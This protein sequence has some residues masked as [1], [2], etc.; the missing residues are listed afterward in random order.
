M[1]KIVKATVG[2]MVVTII[3]KLLGFMREIVLGS[4][5]GATF[6]SD[7]YITAMN[8]PS[9]IFLSVGTAIGTIFIPIYNENRTLRGEKDSLNFTNNIINTFLISTLIFTIILFIFVKPLVSIFAMGFEGEKL[10]ITIK[11]T[12]IM[13]FGGIFLV[14]SNIITAYLQS[15][16]NFVIPGL[17]GLPFNIIIIISMIISSKTS[18]YILPIGTLIAISSQL[19]FQLPF[20]YKE[21]YKYYF[22]IDLK[23]KNL[24][25]LIYLIAP[26]FIGATVNQVNSIVD[27]TL[28]STLIDGTISALNYANRLTD[29]VIIL[30]TTSIASVMY[31]VFSKL[32]IEKESVEFK[33]SIT[34]SV[35]SIILLIVPISI[36]TIVLAKPIVKILFERGNFDS[37][38]TYMTYTALQFYA[39]G[40]IGFSIRDIL[41]KIFYS[42]QDSKTPMINGV[43]TVCMNILLNLIFIK[44]MGHIGLALAT[45]IS[46]IICTILLFISLNRKVC[47]FKQQKIVKTLIKSLIASITMGLVIR[48][49]YSSISTITNLGIIYNVIGI[50]ITVS[51]GVIIYIAIIKV[52]KVEEI[53]FIINTINKKTRCAS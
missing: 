32:S 12:K 7:I 30:F 9:I 5:Y 8:I 10:D 39:I 33:N 20:A 44:Y 34:T 13:I 14:L 36:G 19:L 4:T 50:V 31:P 25:K 47:N 48:K 11:F 53:D 26:V 42:L 1:S 27:R 29:F 28:A 2:L 3:S 37:Y 45:S 43:I 16:E 18:I 51:I 38:A 24:V 46:A 52:L 21:Q 35:N 49:I 23:D 17:I 40:M 6:Y 22:K 15:R 41:T